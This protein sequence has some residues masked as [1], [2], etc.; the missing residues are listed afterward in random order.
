MWPFKRKDKS[1]SPLIEIKEPTKELCIEILA[2][3]KPL[4]REVAAFLVNRKGLPRMTEEDARLATK[5][6]VV[7]GYVMLE[8]YC[9][10][11]GYTNGGGQCH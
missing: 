6:M 5:S 1:P 8:E 3:K 2:M 11:M 10:E 7:R 4:D 9:E